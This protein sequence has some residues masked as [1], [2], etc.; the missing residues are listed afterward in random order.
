MTLNYSNVIQSELGQDAET[1]HYTTLKDL[2]IYMHNRLDADFD[3]I[4]VMFV[5]GDHK[6]IIPYHDENPSAL[7]T[8][9]SNQLYFSIKNYFAK[10]PSHIYNV[11][12]FDSYEAALNYVKDYVETSSK[13]YRNEQ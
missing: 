7:I 12:E 9:N 1:T 2:L 11:F 3:G 5:T 13:A 4:Y 6:K 10:L 8:R